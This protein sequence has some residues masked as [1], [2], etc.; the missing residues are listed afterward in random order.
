MYVYNPTITFV[1]KNSLFFAK[2]NSIN[3]L[4]ETII[5]SFINTF[6]FLSD[7][8]NALTYTFMGAK[9]LVGGSRL[10]ALVGTDTATAW[11]AGT[12]P[13]QPGSFFLL[14]HSF[15]TI[16]HLFHGWLNTEFKKI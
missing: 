3:S 16:V 1:N 10:Y 5:I 14:H 12:A 7:L 2:S 11:G 8:E 13:P 9:Q 6:S 4:V 15:S